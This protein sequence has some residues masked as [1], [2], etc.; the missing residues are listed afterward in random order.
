[1]SERSFIV[2]RPADLA[3][4][5]LRALDASEGRRKRR[6]RDTTPDA[7]G[8]A[9]RRSLLE[10]VVAEDPAPDRLEAWLFDRCSEVGEGSGPIRAVSQQLWEE[11]RLA[12]HSPAFRSWLES[13]APSEDVDPT[14]SS[15][16]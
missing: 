13:G 3:R 14:S 9:L 16:R 2:S 7:I 8:F 11:W 10:R 12:E 15:S 4:S 1:M 5:L 6:A